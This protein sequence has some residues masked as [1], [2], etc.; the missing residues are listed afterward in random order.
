M[1][2]VLATI[3]VAHHHEPRTF[4][5]LEVEVDTGCTYTAVPRQLLE[6]LG[7]PVTR[8]ERSK[9]AD[10][11]LQTL[12]VGDATIRLEGIEFITTVICAAEGEPNLLGMIALEQA[13]LAVDP[14]NNRLISV[15]AK[16]Y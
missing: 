13:L 14:L 2:T 11:T 10:G 16:R 5:P 4:Q 6:T 1:G 15:E 7:V 12:E 9:L 8:V 3:Q